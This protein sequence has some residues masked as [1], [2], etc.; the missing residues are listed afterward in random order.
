MWTRV[1]PN[2]DQSQA[3]VRTA[4]RPQCGPS[5]ALQWTRVR[6]KS[7]RQTGVGVDQGQAEVSTTV[8]L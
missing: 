2:D 5:Q 1:S 6:P 7:V 4:V 3:L 8:S